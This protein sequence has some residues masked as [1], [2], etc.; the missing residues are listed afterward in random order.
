VY[1][2]LIPQ[3]GRALKPGGWLMLEIG[4]GQGPAVASL[5]DGWAGVAFLRDLQGIARVA[6]AQKPSTT[7]KK[8]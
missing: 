7:L 8:D 4:Y 1:E 6:V 5:L 2:Q 3:A